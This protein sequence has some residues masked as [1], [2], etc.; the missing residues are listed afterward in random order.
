MRTLNLLVVVW[1][2]THVAVASGDEIEPA[3]SRLVIRPNPAAPWG[4]QVQDVEKV[5]YSSA[6]P[7]WQ[8]F[9]N[10]ELKPILV[11]PKGGPITLFE[12]G[13]AGEYR[14]R[15]N[16]GDRLWAQHAFQFS[17]EFC[18]IL[19]GYRAGPNRNKWFEE[20]MCELASLF[21]LRQMSESWKTAPPYPNWK[22]YSGA[23]ASYADDRMK[24]S[25]LPPGE[26]LAD[27]YLAHE[28]QLAL[29]A[30]NRDFNLVVAGALLPMFERQPQRWESG[31]F[32]NGT[33]PIEAQSFA[34]Y[35]N[36]WHQRCPPRLQAGVVEIAQQFEITIPVESNPVRDQV[37]ARY[38]QQIEAL[39][40]QI[41]DLRK[42][43]DSELKE[44]YERQQKE[45]AGK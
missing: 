45:R 10:R 34:V 43:R 26:T 9:P 28:D 18:H 3:K 4:G 30:V 13:P 11:E 25:K 2:F 37:K 6:E 38:D 42:K 7:L 14:V 21:A 12:R 44:L 31:E 41:Q 29:D 17:H 32:L 1:L 36:D 39:N 8:H 40:S 33:G 5:L 27:W 19:C 23:L 20:S 24:N 22:D 15:L 16:T 35:L